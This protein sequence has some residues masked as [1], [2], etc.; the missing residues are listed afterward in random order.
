VAGPRLLVVGALVWLA[1]AR[2]LVHR[3]SARAAFGAGMIELP[4]GK[5]EPGEAPATALLREL[6][7]EWG[8]NA[9]ALV[10]GPIADVLHHVYPA[11]GPEVVLLVYHV[12]GRAWGDAWARELV[13]DEGFE[14]L[15]FPLGDLPVAEFLEADRDFAAALARGDVRCPFDRG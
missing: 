13:S 15:A 6:V 4:G 5:V 8:A 2:V 12:D 1:P 14:P 10:V 11:P 7:E 9:R 3:R